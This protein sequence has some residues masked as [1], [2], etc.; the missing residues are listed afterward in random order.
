MYQV[1][2]VVLLRQ[3]YSL[4]KRKLIILIVDDNKFFIERMIGLLQ[5]AEGIGYINVAHDY[6]EA[7][8]CINQERPDLVLLDIN[9]PGKNGID[10]LREIKQS[11]LKCS[12]VMI[13]NHD[14]EYYRQQCK[15]LGA[16]HFLDKSTDFGMVPMIINEIYMS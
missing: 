10:L 13:S 15:Q 6:D 5:E 3:N 1:H 2:I 12:V 8:Q 16:E 14:N 11:D 9:L 7:Y 4:L